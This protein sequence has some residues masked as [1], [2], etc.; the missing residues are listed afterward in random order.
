MWIDSV[1]LPDPQK[2]IISHPSL[3]FFRQPVGMPLRC[4]IAESNP[5]R[6]SA[7]KVCPIFGY[8]ELVIKNS[9][10]PFILR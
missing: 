3:D 10:K 6:V 4:T 7:F 1:S 8:F 9:G 2:L 5:S